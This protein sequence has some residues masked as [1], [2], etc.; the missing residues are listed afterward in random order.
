MREP[1]AAQAI[2]LFVG[3][4]SRARAWVIPTDE[5][6]MIAIHAVQLRFPLYL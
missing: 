1:G 2:E 6:K 3:E 5:E 4:A